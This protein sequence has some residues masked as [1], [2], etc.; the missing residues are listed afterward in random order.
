MPNSFVFSPDGRY[1]YGS[2]Y[3]TGV[4]NLF[5]YD[6]QALKL[7]AMTNTETGFFRPIP[8]ADGSADR[9][10]LLGSRD[11]CRRASTRGRSRTSRRLR[12]SP[13]V[14][15]E[16]HPVV[17]EWNVGSPARIPFD[18]MPQTTRK[19]RLAGGMRRESFY[20]IL[21]GYKDTAAV[22]MRFN[23]SD[24][25]QLNRAN[26]VVSY[27]PSSDLPSEERVHAVAEY[28]RFDWRGRAAY[29]GADFYDL[30]GPTKTG[31]KG[32]AVSVGHKNTLIFDEPRRLELDL[33]GEFA[34]NLDR[35]PDYQNVAVDVDRLLTFQAAL[36]YTDVRNSLGYVD[37]ETG[38]K[39]SLVAQAQRVEG[40][41]VPRFFGSYDRGFALPIGHSSLWFRGAAGFS[42]SSRD[43]PFA[44]FY[45]GGFGNNYVDHADEKRY[46]RVL[47]LSGFELNEVP[48]RNFLRGTIEW[49]LPPW[50]FRRMGTP[51]FH[52]TWARPAIFVSGLATN[53]DDSA[54]RRVPVD[55][56]AQLDFRFSL[57]SVLDL[58]VSA[59]AA[60]AFEDGHRPQQEAMFSLKIS[61]L[62]HACE[63]A[64]GSTCRSCCF[65]SCSTSWT[66]S[67]WCRADRCSARSPTVACA[68]SASS[69]CTAG[70]RSR[71]VAGHRQPV[72]GAADRGNG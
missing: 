47:Q 27:S 56:G 44:N 51:G 8:M 41:P 14:V 62:S 35:L 21:Q 61:A 48:G 28:H 40:A 65:W 20:P 30:F 59:G 6:L 17:K 7:D 39:W 34:G 19:Y 70:C 54:F 46:R 42:P 22:G 55:V 9:V 33:E 60:M 53:L 2:A 24:P 4:S 71:A 26:F 25:L 58:T 69:S 66:A 10:P 38:R 63:R 5:R 57:L 11:S 16:E 31:R 64:C 23:I 3:L 49:N 18:S 1:V 36:S 67:S 29:N 43:D 68:R 45:F 32:Y 50:R 13:S 52:A 37:D 72:R 12:S 15:A